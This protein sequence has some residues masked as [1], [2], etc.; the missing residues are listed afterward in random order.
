MFSLYACSCPLTVLYLVFKGDTKM[1]ILW[2]YFLEQHFRQQPIFIKHRFSSN[3]SILCLMPVFNVAAQCIMCSMINDKN[4]THILN[5][6][7]ILFYMTHYTHSMKCTCRNRWQLHWNM[8]VTSHHILNRL[9][10]NYLPVS[11]ICGGNQ[12][13][14][15]GSFF[16]LEIIIY[17]LKV[18]FH[19]C[20]LGTNWT[21]NKCG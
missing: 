13:R 6:K 9:T 10:L 14:G 18:L 8:G 1:P 21:N 7:W 11:L 12:L 20:M 3:N 19:H 2:Q 4:R 16:Q 15:Y 5:F 17:K